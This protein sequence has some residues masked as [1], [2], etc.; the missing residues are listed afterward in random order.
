MKKLLYLVAEDN[1]FCSHRLNLGKAALKAGFEVAVATR[2]QQHSQK[3]TEAGLQIFPLKNFTRAGL[4]PIRQILAFWELYHIYKKFKPTIV[5]HV[6]MKPIVLGSLVARFCHINKVINALGGLGYLFTEDRGSRHHS[7]PKKTIKKILLRKIVLSL[8]R[9]FF[10]QPNN[11]LILQNNDDLDILIK[12]GCLVKASKVAIIRGAGVDMAA[13]PI[14]PLP[15]SPP[16]IIACVARMLW[17]KGI[18]ELIEAAK[19]IKEQHYPIKIKLYGAPDP[20]NPASISISQLQAW[21]DTGLIIWQGYCQEVA[22]AYAD[23][24]IAVLASY[25]EGLPKSLLEAASMGRPIITTNVPGCCEV[26]EEGE[27][28]FLVPAKE[29]EK[30]A[31]ALI[32]LGTN[33]ALRLKMGLASRK[34]VENY[35]SDHLI[36]HATLDLYES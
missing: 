8:F 31:E 4:N 12:S 22:K 5:H 25:R 29:S 26:V 11:T 16:I 2:C 34:R 10:S 35:F 1:Y 33:E 30:L 14:T 23:C 17:T 9:Y 20:D 36:H 13:F 15:S 27:N 28:G 18:G 24:H 32:R 7:F 6:A 19:I 3:I 21:H